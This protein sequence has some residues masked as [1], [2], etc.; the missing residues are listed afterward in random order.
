MTKLTDWNPIVL[1]PIETKNLT[2]ADV[3]RLT[4]STRDSMLEAMMSMAKQ[5]QKVEPSRTNGVSTAIEI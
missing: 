5:T 3:D 2:P 4:V 1:P